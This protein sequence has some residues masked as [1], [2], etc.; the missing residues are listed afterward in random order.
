MI[1]EWFISYCAWEWTGDSLYASDYHF[2]DS[3]H[4]SGIISRRK[5][6]SFSRADYSD[7]LIFKYEYEN[8]SEHDYQQV[9]L[10]LYADINVTNSSHTDDR[11]GYIDSLGLSYFYD[12]PNPSEY[13]GIKT[14]SDVPHLG[15]SF[16][17]PE[18]MPYEDVYLYEILADTT[19][20]GI[21]PDTSG[22]F[23]VYIK[24]GPYFLGPLD[25]ISIFYG[26]AAGQDFQKMTVNAVKMQSLFDSL[27]T[28]VEE[29]VFTCPQ[30]S[31]SLT[32]N[33]SHGRIMIRFFLPSSSHA[34]IELLDLCGRKLQ[35]DFPGLLREGT[36]EINLDLSSL[37]SGTYFLM[38]CSEKTNVM[39][40]ITLI[41]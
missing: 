27:F 21:I 38:L 35:L 19:A 24:A 20:P 34:K 29:P 3:E 40:R 33:P 26:I 8:K 17:W 23:A 9:Y 31:F 39:K 41:K 32:P 18:D 25:S 28:S 37:P 16:H 6:F 10:G 30:S 13:I 15:V 14:L 4:V 5:C 1:N 2:D 11:C 12:G 7:F 36:N 22:S